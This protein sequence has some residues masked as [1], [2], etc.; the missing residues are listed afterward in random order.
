MKKTKRKTGFTLVELL[1]VVAIIAVLVAMLLPALQKARNQTKAISCAANWKQIGIYMQLYRVDFSRMPPVST[2]NGET[3]S[4][5]DWN[6][7][8][9]CAFG[10]F[11]PYVKEANIQ[12]VYAL[13]TP[14]QKSKARG[15]FFDPSG[16]MLGDGALLNINYIL[17]YTCPDSVEPWGP[18]A[19]L[20]TFPWPSKNFDE[21]PSGTAVG[22]CDVWG[23]YNFPYIPSGHNNLGVNILYLDGHVR[24]KPTSEFSGIGLGAPDPWIGYKLAFNQ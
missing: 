17:P 16:L 22:V 19:S 20:S 6:I 13:P 24:W 11:Q 10:C 18:T 2:Y 15:V 3:R 23:Y 21:N 12:F 9:W 7:N 14:E 1:V 4:V 5:Y 8:Q